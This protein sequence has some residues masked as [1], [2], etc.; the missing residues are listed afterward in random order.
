MAFVL[1]ILFGVVALSIMNV[2]FMSLY[3]RMFEFGVLRAVGTRPRDMALLV[4]LEAACLGL[5]SAA[6]GIIMGFGVTAL[7]GVSGIDYVG[8]EYAGVTFRE[9]IYP[10]M[11]P[12]QFVLYP[13]CVI[14]FALLAALYPAVYAARLRPAEAMRRSV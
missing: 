7:I 4:V 12:G 9:L 14:V 2:L 10:V 3:E 13:L 1:V 5:V 11:R 8:V 6:L